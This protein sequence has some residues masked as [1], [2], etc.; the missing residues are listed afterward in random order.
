VTAV[1]AA[2]LVVAVA[3]ALLAGR[4]GP[5]V[6]LVGA[7]AP[8]AAVVALVVVTPA[9]LD[10]TVE[11]AT[12]S[13][14]PGLNLDFTMRLDAFGLLLAWLVAGIGV[15]V[16]AYAWQ[17][18]GG[19]G[20]PRDDLGRMSATLVLFAASML[21]LVTAD[22]VLALF[23]FWELTTVTSFLLIG[24]DDRNGA[25]RAAALRAALTTGAGGL[26]MLGGLVLL[27]IQADTWTLSGLAADPPPGSLAVGV[28]AACILVG[29]M[30]KS[31]Q[32][33]FH[34]WLPGA[35]AAPTPISAYLHS[36]TM[37]KAGVYLVARMAPVL[38]PEVEWWRPTVVTV[39]VVTMVIG[40][41][42]ALRQND[43]KLLLAFGTVSQLGLM[44]ALFGV[45]EPE[46]TA[47]GC[48]V[49]LAHA[50]FKSAL[51][52]TVGII[53]HQAH[54][55]D[56]RRLRGLRH[57]LPVVA[58]V[59]A[60]AAASMAGI[61]PLFG[62]V[63][64]E[65][66]LEA[67]LDLEGS[68]LLA[69]AVIV[70][71]SALTVAY[72]LRYWWGGFGDATDSGIHQLVGEVHAP[73]PAFVAP[74]VLLAVPT[75]VF[76]LVPSL[77]AEL[78]GPAA[79]ALIPGSG[80]KGLSLWHGV[81]VALGL[82]VVAV[83]AGVL[84]FVG[85][86]AVAR[87]QSRLPRIGTG[88]GAYDASVRGANVFADRLTGVLQNGSLPT[89]L[90]VILLTAVTLPTV[91]LVHGGTD[92]LANL[93]GAESIAQVGAAVAACVAAVAVAV[94]RRRFAAAL[95]LGAVGYSVSL[96]FVVQGAPDLAL[97][98]LLIETLSVVLFV[99]VF[100]HLPDRFE[101]HRWN[102]SHSVRLVVSVLVG[103]F[104]TGAILFSTSARV[105]PSISEN[106]IARAQPEAGGKNIVNVIIVDFRG[107]DTMG[108]IAVLA[109]AALGVAGLVAVG[110]RRPDGD[111]DDGDADSSVDGVVDEAGVT[112]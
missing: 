16:M 93:V 84:M 24:T 28:A 68:A 37:V 10:G 31:A 42:R 9:V 96:L 58:G 11:S 57:Q 91:A 29:A 74:A 80:E 54:T 41:W 78:T 47:A 69:V 4:L 53:D 13:W 26:V 22:N 19:H 62:F 105:D 48:A 90:T 33:P 94:T 76:G 15:M 23:V 14:V 66:A 65:S 82:S 39:G 3:C 7:L 59:A 8:L 38:A 64:K 73:A 46:A 88:E 112:A 20:T 104:M 17:Y 51:F 97:T 56:L 89:Y 99:L 103:V 98:Q 52:L 6:F 109:L 55:R 34:F 2:H 5:R 85:R 81:N 27:A 72:S 111:A 67:F 43:L 63:A 106:F 79:D 87:A 45:G 95:L 110:R 12:V 102:R 107:Y 60:V 35:M 108:E 18:F 50:L 92:G 30:T 100:R 61:P 83:T 75:V 77:A 25:A 21:G 86:R 49:L 40:G 101:T 36:A 71:A 32:A 1:F 70:A 44:F